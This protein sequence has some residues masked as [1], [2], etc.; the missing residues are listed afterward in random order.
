M[1]L[2]LFHFDSEPLEIRISK[3]RWQIPSCATCSSHWSS[4]LRELR[5][6]RWG[7]DG[8][9]GWRATAG[10]MPRLARR[11]CLVIESSQS[12]RSSIILERRNDMKHMM[13]LRNTFTIDQDSG[14]L[15]GFAQFCKMKLTWRLNVTW[16]FVFFASS[17]ISCVF[18]HGLWG[19]RRARESPQTASVQ[20]IAMAVL[21]GFGS[22][23]QLDL[24][25][26]C[27]SGTS[28]I[29]SKLLDIP[30]LYLAGP[31]CWNLEELKSRST[32]T[33][34]SLPWYL[35]W[36]AI[37]T[38]SFWTA[39]ARSRRWPYG[40]SLITPLSD[41][42]TSVTCIRAT[43][44]GSATLWGLIPSQTFFRYQN[45]ECHDQEVSVTVD[46][47]VVSQRI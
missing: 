23:Y 47:N 9:R 43:F 37:K 32:W 3:H 20:H 36:R 25:G 10:A 7:P 2:H 11:L 31:R 34:L 17:Q 4:D 29:I 41:G 19:R 27:Y 28:Q 12:S 8:G 5:E 22:L 33:L 35:F 6:L 26:C 24:T 21:K 45:Q 18:W 14:G 30:V 13:E 15:I 1:V 44:R 39:K 42:V 16:G 38:L 46:R 40:C